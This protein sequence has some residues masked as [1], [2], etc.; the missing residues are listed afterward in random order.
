MKKMLFK[1]YTY[2]FDKNEKK[3]ITTFCKQAVQQLQEENKFFSE[4]NSFNSIMQKMKSGPEPVKLTKDEA[5]R[6]ETQLKENMKHVKKEMSK[7]WFIKK[8]LYKSVYN[9]YN[10]LVV[11]HFSD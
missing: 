1:S 6:L 5:K 10:S 9:Q 7:S 2:D 3:I 4:I 11:K 8:W